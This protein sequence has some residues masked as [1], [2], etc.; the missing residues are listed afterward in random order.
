MTGRIWTLEFELDGVR[1]EHVITVSKL[2]FV[3][4]MVAAALLVSCSGLFPGC[5]GGVFTALPVL[6][7]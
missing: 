6:L 7:P 4:Y 2:C 3:E 1:S 5:F